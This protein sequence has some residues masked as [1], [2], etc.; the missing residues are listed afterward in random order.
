MPE[1]LRIVIASVVMLAAG[2]TTIGCSSEARP[3]DLTPMAASALISQRWSRDE[4][5]HFAVSFHSDELIECGVKND[6][7]KLVEGSDRGYAWTA[8]RLTP[9]GTQILFAID[10]KTSGKGH[11]ITLRGP[12][13]F[14]ITGISPGSQP[15]SRIVEFQWQIDWDKAPADLKACLPKFE[16]SGREIALFKLEGIDWRF[17][18]YL[19]PEDA[20]T[21]QGATPALDKLP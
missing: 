9:K 1:N 12:Y 16:L 8:Y 2:V 13:R 10:L 14:D 11:E 6:L 15:D 7:W 5:N 20:P 21:A 19:K 18:S 4:L 3:V 17:V